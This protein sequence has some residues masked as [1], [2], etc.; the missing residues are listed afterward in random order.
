M[1]PAAGVIIT[2]PEMAPINV[3]SR[4]H[5]PVSKYVID[6][7]VNAPAEA[8]RF[9]TASALI[10]KKLRLSVVPA[11]KAS[12]LPQMMTRARSWLSELCGLWSFKWDGVRTDDLRDRASG[13]DRYRLIAL[14]VAP[15]QICTGV[16]PAKS[17]TPSS[18]KNPPP[19]TMCASGQYM[20]VDHSWND[21][22]VSV[23]LNESALTK[24]NGISG[25]ILPRS[26]APPTAMAHT[27]ASKTSWN[28]LNKRAG[29]VPTG[30]APTPRCRAYWKLPITPPDPSP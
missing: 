29:I 16:P 3:E 4:D 28:M 10:D 11:S 21:Q 6:A 8:H 13:Y 7:H 25:R 2:R 23:S 19:H 24:M 12:Q 9:V 14:A 17:S 20:N 5:L 27:V 26:Q 15:E 30:S 1:N 18:D 22:S